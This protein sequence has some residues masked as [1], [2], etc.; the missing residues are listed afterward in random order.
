MISN[1]R[2]KNPNFIAVVSRLANDKCYRD[3]IA[4]KEVY[5]SKGLLLGD[6]PVQI[7]FVNLSQS[8]KSFEY[9]PIP[10]TWLA[11]YTENHPH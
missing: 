4:L 8:H 5:R 10:L 1:T 11:T 3:M 9:N 6:Q 2:G 7:Q